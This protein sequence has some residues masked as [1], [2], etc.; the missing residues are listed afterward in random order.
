MTRLAAEGV[1]F[2]YEP[3][4][5][6]VRDVSLA[7]DAGDMLAIAGPNGSGKSTLLDLL[8]GVR[9]PGVGRVTLDGQDLRTL[10]R[11]ALARAIAVVPQDAAITFPY[12]VAE[13]VLMG[14]APHRRRF[15]IETPRDVAIAE[16]AMARTGVLSL[17]GRPITE[18]SGGERQ[19]VVIAR[20]LAQE[21]AILLLDEPTTHLDLRHAAEVME[22]VGELNATDGTA[23]VAVLHDLTSAA[24]YFRRLA[25][26]RDGKVAAE[27]P[28]AAV[29]EPA[30]IRAVYD[31]EVRVSADEDG[32][33]FVRPRRKSPKAAD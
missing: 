23:V 13:I 14:R 18:L 19:R 29:V 11:R 6:V 33:L 5:P 2:A 24:L 31:A 16:Q 20:A 4:T 30:T 3:G 25:F 32:V 15:G 10:D 12:T 8:S 22:L 7:I 28:P 26:L 9:M 17:A 21:P 1:S 27:G